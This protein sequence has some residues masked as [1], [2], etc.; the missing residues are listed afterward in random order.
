M[1]PFPSAFREATVTAPVKKVLLD[2]SA[3]FEKLVDRVKPEPETV[4]PIV[5]LPELP[6]DSKVW[7]ALNVMLSLIVSLTLLA[8]SAI[9]PV[10]VKPL[11][12]VVAGLMVK[13]AAVALKLIAARLNVDG[14]IKLSVNVV[15]PTPVALV[16]ASVSP[17][18]GIVEPPQFPPE[19][20]L[21]QFPLRVP[22]HVS[23]AA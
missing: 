13:A 16:K 11:I 19:P 3:L 9:P 21:A 4:P 12:L 20:S 10:R 17:L 18:A 6:A 14:V 5:R 8:R 7:L 1:P 22:D 23:V 2:K 15:P